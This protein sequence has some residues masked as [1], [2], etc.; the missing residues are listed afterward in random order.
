MSTFVRSQKCR[1]LILGQVA[2][3]VSVAIPMVAPDAFRILQ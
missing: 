1:G 3:V 2:L